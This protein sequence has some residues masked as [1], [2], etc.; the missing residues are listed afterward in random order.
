[1]D[2]IIDAIVACF[3]DVTFELKDYVNRGKLKQQGQLMK[4]KSRLRGRVTVQGRQVAAKAVLRWTA[5]PALPS[6]IR[7]SRTGAAAT[8]SAGGLTAILERL[9]SE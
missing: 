9:S 4:G 5:T 6:T 8:T 2:D 7:A 3:P 1:V